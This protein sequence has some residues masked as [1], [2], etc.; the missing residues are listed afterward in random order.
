METKVGIKKSTLT[1]LPTL[2]TLFFFLE[3]FFG[4]Q[5]F[6]DSLLS[7]MS[8]RRGLKLLCN[9]TSTFYFSFSSF[10][11]FPTPP[12][13]AVEN[14]CRLLC[15]QNTFC[16]FPLTFALAFPC[17]WNTTET[18]SSVIW[19]SVTPLSAAQLRIFTTPVRISQ[20]FSGCLKCL[21][22]AQALDLE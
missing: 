22:K 14:C 10:I 6:V 9:L 19:N 3:I 21:F 12:P 17:V 15:Y 18:H 13:F 4:D 5:V 2:I 7:P 1:L 11:S 8:Q 20:F 16:T